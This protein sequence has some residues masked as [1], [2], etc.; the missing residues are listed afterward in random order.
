MRAN[1]GEA[2][3]ATLARYDDTRPVRA[4]TKELSGALFDTEAPLTPAQAEQ[5][6]DIM[7]AHSRNAAGK[8]DLAAM[9]AEAIVAEAAAVLSPA[10]LAV[11]RRAQA[12]TVR[13][14]VPASGNAPGN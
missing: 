14:W 1:F 2:A 4:V 6:V 3:A 11:F 8:V 7:A 12:E 5:L 9:N 10:Q 13:R